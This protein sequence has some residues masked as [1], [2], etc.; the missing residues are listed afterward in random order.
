ML[1]ASLRC[2][3]IQLLIWSALLPAGAM[4]R[5]AAQPGQIDFNR[6]IRPILSENCFYCHGQDPNHRKKDLR[7]D[8]RESA[9]KAKA[10]VPGQA[11]QSEL[12]KRVFTDDPQDLMPPPESHRT[13]SAAQ[14]ETLKQ[15]I[16]Q[17][18]V[19]QTHWSYAAPQRPALPEVKR[20]G[21]VCNPIDAFV[22]ARLE[23]EGL[24]P[25]PQASRAALIRR[26]SLDL[27]GLPPTPAQVD[28]FVADQSSDAYEKVV[29]R[30]LASDAYGERMALPWLDAARYADSNGFQQD[31]DTFQWVWRD[32]V[33]RALNADMPFDEFSTDQLAGDL[34][35]NATND[36]KIAT[37]FNRNHLLNGE[38]GAIAEEQRF[39]ILFDRVDTTATNWLGLTMACAQCHDHKYDPI[40]QHDYYG[41][42]AAFNQVPETGTPGGG[43]GRIRVATPLL[44]L[45]SDENKKKLGDMEGELKKVETESDAKKKQE[46]EFAKWEPTVTPETP[47]INRDLLPILRSEPD[48]RTDAEQDKLHKGLRSHFD[49][50][51]WP[52]MAAK[53]PLLK[54]AEAL[55]KEIARYKNEDV[56]RVMVMSDAQHRDTFILERGQYLSPRQKV[57]F[58]TPAF[59]PP[60]ADGSPR[61]RLGFARWLFMPEN[62]LTARVQV[63]RYWQL[64]FGTGLVKTSED[65]GVQSEYPVYKD[66]LDWLAV[67]FRQPSDDSRP[68]S[69]K[70]IQRLIVTSATYRQSSRITPELLARDPENR[71]LARASR[72]RLPAMTL[73][74]LALS[75]SGLL[76][77]KIGGQPVYPYQPEG[78]WDGLA[79][80]K[81]RDFTYPL[82]SGPDLYRRS[83]YTFWRRTASPA[84]V[85][86]NANRQT[87][88]VRS[89]VT[90]TPLH[91]L[92]MLND[93]TWVEAARVLAAKAMESSSDSD[94][95]DAALSFAFRQVLGRAPTAEELPILKHMLDG[96]RKLYQNDPKGA[97]ALTTVGSSPPA[98]S[99]DVTEHAALSAVCLA[100]LNMDEAMSHE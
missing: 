5:A 78:V 64:F 61:N 26:V 25:S 49:K 70:H 73:R 21:W 7:L 94:G 84:D 37:A 95:P 19:Y 87:C 100:I 28:A 54:R 11:E 42:M 58:A 69:M 34:I 63:N 29:D 18:A 90:C 91:A 12:I 41:L 68:W 74:D 14:K 59:L 40:T 80:T 88:R 16:A 57:E 81:E 45:P 76:N 32:W 55:K 71:L 39:N 3:P 60:M 31:G 33:V 8:I 96:Q 83:I 79:I 98:K 51:V 65:L 72:F 82:S 17:G 75:T 86:D 15:W 44:E 6:D 24:S 35:P 50:N 2:F 20:Q 22:L 56:P 52:E 43:P 66:L 97:V 89:A 77:A 36:Q 9:L 38:G 46:E 47:G 93:K 48:E 13:L 85:F 27:T 23:S 62:P 4:A 1:M 67:E 10:F 53:N 30:L 99:L 92:T